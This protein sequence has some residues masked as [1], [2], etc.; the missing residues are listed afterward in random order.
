MTG[1]EMRIERDAFGAVEIPADRYWG[2]QTQRALAVFDIGDSERLP[3]PCPHLRPAEARRRARKPPPRR[4]CRPQLA[5]P[6]E[7]GPPELWEGRFD[8]HFPCR[9]GR[10]APA[11]RPT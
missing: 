2:A 10:R 7:A 9:S 3:L 4:A 8:D 6:I 5:E 1:Q 11:R